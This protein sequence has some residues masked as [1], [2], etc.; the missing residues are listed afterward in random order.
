MLY[1]YYYFSQRIFYVR[2]YNL[3]YN[4]QLASTKKKTNVSPSES[5]EPFC[6]VIDPLKTKFF[7]LTIENLNG[8][9]FFVHKKTLQLV[10]GDHIAGGTYRHKYM[11][12]METNTGR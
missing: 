9:V 4:K 7:L 10:L 3:Y 5:I 6:P 1:I 2:S 11:C 12:T 8:L